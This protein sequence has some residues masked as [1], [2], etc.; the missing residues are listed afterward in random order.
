MCYTTVTL[1]VSRRATKSQAEVLPVELWI[2]T[3]VR[4][5]HGAQVAR[6]V[7]R[8]S[9]AQAVPTC[10]SSCHQRGKGWADLRFAS[11]VPTQALAGGRGAPAEKE[12][13]SD[14]SSSR[15]VLKRGRP[16]VR[17]HEYAAHV[18]VSELRSSAKKKND[19][20]QKKRLA[21]PRLPLVG[22]AV[23]KRQEEKQL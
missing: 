15:L 21:A 20:K 1:L 18:G 9:A 6:V 3:C 19:K 2:M 11:E 10:W 12:G 14:E 22:H 23:D 8:N 13:G 17:S 7:I 5:W 16:A 4:L